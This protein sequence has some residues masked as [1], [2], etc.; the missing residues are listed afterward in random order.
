MI[1]LFSRR[2]EKKQETREAIVQIAKQLFFEK[3]YDETTTEEIAS[4]ADIA[5]GTLFNYF[6][7]KADLLV[8]VFSEGLD[9][10]LDDPE[11][12]LSDEDLNKAASDLI[13]QYIYQRVKRYRFISQKMFKDLLITSISALKKKPELL[14]KFIGLDFMLVDNL[15]VFMNQLKEK[16]VLSS[17]F[18]S[19][20]AAEVIYSCLAFEFLMC[21]YQEDLTFDD[22]LNG[23]KQK[24]QFIFS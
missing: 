20:Q 14:K 23:T 4:K 16:G 5:S 15:I 11:P 3:G 22:F 10:D 9:E 7:T 18:D 19:N 1:D 13:Y 6:D 17:D 21:M 12:G 2:N 24:L 8:E